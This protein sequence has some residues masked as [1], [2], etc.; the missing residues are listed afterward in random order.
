M[1]ARLLL[2]APLL[3]LLAPLRAAAQDAPPPGDP[4]A[5]VGEDIVVRATYGRTTML[6]DKA[7]DGTL[8]NCRIMISS[9]S[10]K[11]DTDACKATPVCYEKTRDEVTDCVELTALEQAQIAPGAVAP[12]KDGAVPVFSMPQL[13]KP[14]T[15]SM[16]A[17]GPVTVTEESAETGRQRVGKLPPPPQA[18]TDGPLIRLTTG[19]EQ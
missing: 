2:F 9:G 12:A 13:V 4:E 15:P 8:R 6:F 10:Q 17:T 5:V 19:Q 7:A 11:R 14:R 1:I 3:L 18:P 16:P